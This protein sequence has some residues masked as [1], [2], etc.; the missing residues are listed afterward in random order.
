MCVT[1]ER[2]FLSAAFFRESKYA[3]RVAVVKGKQD[4]GEG[5]KLPAPFQMFDTTI[6]A[7]DAECNLLAEIEAEVPIAPF[8][9]G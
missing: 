8:D 3:L 9:L 5:N 4:S 1:A 2:P 7:S 6:Q